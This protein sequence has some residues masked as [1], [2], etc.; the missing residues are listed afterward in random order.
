MWGGGGLG[1]D[2]RLTWDSWQS[3]L[4]PGWESHLWRGAAVPTCPTCRHS[5]PA[6]GRG[7]LGP[8]VLPACWTEQGGSAMRVPR[9]LT[10]GRLL[11]NSERHNHSLEEGC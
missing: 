11:F 4:D 2:L 7:R 8:A 10:A 5:T 6:C 3:L 1:L 9:V